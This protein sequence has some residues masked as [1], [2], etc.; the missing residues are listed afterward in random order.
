MNHTPFIIAAFL[1]TA[2]GTLALVGHSWIAM[3][4]SEALT[5]DLKSRK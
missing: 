4:K 5:D 1:V 3:R 2:L